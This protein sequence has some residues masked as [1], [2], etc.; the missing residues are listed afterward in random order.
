MPLTLC[1][2]WFARR[3]MATQL[4]ETAS[5]SVDEA[6]ERARWGLALLEALREVTAATHTS[7]P[8]ACAV[9]QQCAY[10]R[11]AAIAAVLRADG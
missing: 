3:Q 9:L 6:E 7:L 1:A 2:H 4:L 8:Q 11:Q 5:G 10:D